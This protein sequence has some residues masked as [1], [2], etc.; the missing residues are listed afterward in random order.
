MLHWYVTFLLQLFVSCFLRW[1]NMQ[2][3]VFLSNGLFSIR[4]RLRT[5]RMYCSGCWCLRTAQDFAGHASS[6]EFNFLCQKFA[7]K[8]SCRAYF[9]RIHVAS[10]CFKFLLF[11]NPYLSLMAKKFVYPKFYSMNKLKTQPAEHTVLR[12]AL[13][14]CSSL[15]KRIT[16]HAYTRAAV[17]H[18]VCL[19]A[20][21]KVF[22]FFNSM[23]LTLAPKKNFSHSNLWFVLSLY[24]NSMWYLLYVL[25]LFLQCWYLG[26]NSNF[27]SNFYNIPKFHNTTASNLF[28]ALFAILILKIVV[29]G[30]LCMLSL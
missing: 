6:R 9:L 3:S 14:F 16:S 25:P 2:I 17:S 1:R 20:F 11:F 18:T 28:I 27:N 21:Q 29:V 24:F 23:P 7:S 26:L 15:T 22:V 12:C 5:H 4:R 10:S 13:T 19:A 30:L 8:H